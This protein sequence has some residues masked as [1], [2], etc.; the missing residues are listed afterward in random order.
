MG[1]RDCAAGGRVITGHY[2]LR[3]GELEL[4]GQRGE[5][6]VFGVRGPA[7]VEARVDGARFEPLVPA[8]DA[9]PET[10]SGL[11]AHGDDQ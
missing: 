6:F 3:R 5:H 7:L 10:E 2:A 11:G 9:K 4:I 1:S 8:P